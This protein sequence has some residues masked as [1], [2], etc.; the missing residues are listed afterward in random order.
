MPNTK[1]VFKKKKMLQTI[2][3]IVGGICL[4]IL[5][6]LKLQQY[7]VIVALGL[8][9]FSYYNWRCPKCNKYF[10]RGKLPKY[11]IHCGE[12]LQ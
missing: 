2:I 8:V 6:T 10:G 5:F 7:A 9:G 1:E 12:E 3:P 11:C 4:V